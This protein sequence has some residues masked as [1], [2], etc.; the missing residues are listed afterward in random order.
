VHSGAAPSAAAAVPGR[1]SLQVARPVATAVFRNTQRRW[2]RA[3]VGSTAFCITDTDSKHEVLANVMAQAAPRFGAAAA[4]VVVADIDE[5]VAPDSV[6]PD[7]TVIHAFFSRTFKTLL[8]AMKAMPPQQALEL[9]KD[10]CTIGRNRTKGRVI[11]VI[12]RPPVT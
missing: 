9:A 10:L 5:A 3:A 8:Q 4:G 11:E 6:L 2:L 1:R 7:N 12:G